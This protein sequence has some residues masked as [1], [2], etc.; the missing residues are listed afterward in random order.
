METYVFSDEISWT[1]S[2]TRKSTHHNSTERGLIGN[3]M[4]GKGASLSGSN[5][6]FS[7]PLF[8]LYLEDNFLLHIWYVTWRDS[9]LILSRIEVPTR[10]C[11]SSGPTVKQRIVTGRNLVA[12]CNL[13]SFSNLLLLQ[14]TETIMESLI[15][16]LISGQHSSWNRINFFNSHLFLTLFG[17]F[18]F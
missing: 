12:T 16:L 1:W 13:E 15:H 6:K 18:S 11:F 2:N 14:H 8:Q 10:P 7:A 3:Q 17:T 9:W 4:I 5:L